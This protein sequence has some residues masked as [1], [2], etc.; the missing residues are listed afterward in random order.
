MEAVTEE[1]ELCDFLVLLMTGKLGLT[2]GEPSYPRACIPAR[3]GA[4]TYE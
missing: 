1:A 3:D 4:G 2:L